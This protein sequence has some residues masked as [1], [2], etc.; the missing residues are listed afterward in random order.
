M[1]KSTQPVSSS[2]LVVRNNNVDEGVIAFGLWLNFE[3]KDSPAVPITMKK[4]DQNREV[5][6]HDNVLQKDVSV[7]IV[8][9][10]PICNECRTNDC[11]HVGFAICAEQMHFSSRA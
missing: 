1:R 9:G 10:V 5:V 3:G 6:L 8:E 2:T 11:A 4:F 7:G